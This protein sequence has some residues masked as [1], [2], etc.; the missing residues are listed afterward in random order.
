MLARFENGWFLEVII[1]QDINGFHQYA[2]TVYDEDCLEIRK[3]Y[4]EYRS[5]EMYYPMN[6]IDYMLEFCEP[7]GLEGKYE[8][9][10]QET[11]LDY[12]LY[13]DYGDAYE[14][15]MEKLILNMTKY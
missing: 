8:L 15:K 14:L 5:I 12:E 2:F 6:E 3:G 4:T 10:E 11:M 7:Y 9:F 1:K 13:M